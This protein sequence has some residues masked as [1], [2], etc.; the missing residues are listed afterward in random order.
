MSSATH[1]LPV[2]GMT[3]ASCAGRVERALK[4]VPGLTDIAINP[5]TAEKAG[6]PYKNADGSNDAKLKSIKGRYGPDHVFYNLKSV[7]SDAW[8]VG[9]DGRMCRA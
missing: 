5:I 6:D 1:T 2:S 9:T 3:C 8:T 4:T 7:G